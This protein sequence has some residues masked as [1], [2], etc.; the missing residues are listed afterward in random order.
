VYKPLDYVRTNSPTRPTDRRGT[1]RV[2]QM[3]T[4]CVCVCVG[5]VSHFVLSTSSAIDRI[6][7]ATSR[8]CRWNR[9]HPLRNI[10]RYLVFVRTVHVC[11]LPKGASRLKCDAPTLVGL[12]LGLGQ[13]HTG[14]PW[15]DVARMAT[16]HHFRWK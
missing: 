8:T 1:L 16:F 5:V 11:Y 7:I 15:A 6:V 4:V 10:V 12:W 3:S 2:R 13:S 14:S 9:I